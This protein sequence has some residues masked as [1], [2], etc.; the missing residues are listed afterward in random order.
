LLGNVLYLI[1]I[2]IASMFKALYNRSSIRARE[3]GLMDGESRTTPTI[4]A[5]V[6]FPTRP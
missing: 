4:H 6:L 1:S 2:Q 5:T 3:G